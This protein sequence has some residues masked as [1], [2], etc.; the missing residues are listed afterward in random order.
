MLNA[1]ELASWD[2]ERLWELPNTD[3]KLVFD[4]GVIET[5]GRAIIFSVYMWPF[6]KLYPEM[7]TSTRHHLGDRRVGG[8]THMDM[9]NLIFWDCYDAYKAKGIE[10]DREIMMKQMYEAANVFYNDM[11]Y[12]LEA[13]VRSISIIDFIEVVNH[14]VVKQSNDELEPTN[15]SIERAKKKIKAVLLDPREFIENPIANNAKN[16]LTSITQILHCVGPRGNLTEIDSRVF[17]HPILTGYVHGL[18]LLEDSLKESRSA[19]KALAFSEVPL[20]T[21]EYFNRRLQLMA[22]TVMRLHDGDCGS[23]EYVSWVVKPGDLSALAGKYYLTEKG[24]QPVRANDRHLVGEAIMLRTVFGCKHKDPQ[25]ICATCYGE[26]A[27]SIPK[28]S[29]IGHVAATML[30]EQASQNVLSTKHQ[31]DVSNI[32]TLLISEFDQAFIQLGADPNTVRLA[33]RLE[34]KRVLMTLPSKDA[35][36]INDI[37]Y[38]ENVTQLPLD[39]ISSTGSIKLTIVGTGGPEEIVVIPVSIGSRLASLSYELLAYIKEHGISTTVQGNYEIDLKNWSNE[40]PLLVLPMRHLNMLEYMNVIASFL[41]AS[42]SES[43]DGKKVY[44]GPTLRDF[45]T[46]ERALVEF[47]NIVNSRLKVSISNLEVLIFATMVRS[48]NDLDFALPHVGNTIHFA[49]FSSLMSRRSLSAAMAY[50]HH[51]RVLY[52]PVTYLIDNRMDHPLDIVM[53]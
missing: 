18:R 11:T 34:G 4:D 8:D 15:L 43:K 47:N 29:N 48:P 30:C 26:L 9:L 36:R 52:D 31:D 19:S 46:P 22:A 2:K 33:D 42:T 14:P 5:Y 23:T 37:H 7:P 25:G 3:F 51:K 10:L 13:H 17:P 28:D 45:D 50:E 27:L 41:R 16:G 20:Q 24:L 44:K 49:P 35:A 1:K 21:T 12:R 39:Q 6:Y 40:S 38:V 32:E 53:M